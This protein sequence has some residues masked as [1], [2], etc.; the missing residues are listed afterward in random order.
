MSKT[1]D[2]QFVLVQLP[3]HVYEV[4][5][6]CA[7]VCYRVCISN[8]FELAPRIDQTPSCSKKQDYEC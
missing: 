2:A 3:V 1:A 6:C 4:G 7:W 5:A 8:V